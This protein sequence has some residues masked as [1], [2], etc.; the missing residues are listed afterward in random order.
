[1]LINAYR[2]NT[3]VTFQLLLD[4]CCSNKIHY[5]CLRKPLLSC[6]HGTTFSIPSGTCVPDSENTQ[7]L[8]GDKQACP[9]GSVFSL[10]SSKCIPDPARERKKVTCP[11]GTVYHLTE[12][13]CV[14]DPVMYEVSFTSLK[15]I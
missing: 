4:D 7:T 15:Q 5:V 12:G 14:S 3:D 6:P 13:T 2:Y 11:A 8:S 1:M 10:S 9:S